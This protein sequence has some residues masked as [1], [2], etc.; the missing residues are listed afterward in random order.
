MQKTIDLLIVAGVI[1]LTV[2]FLKSLIDQVDNRKKLSVISY[3][4]G[5]ND[6]LQEMAMVEAETRALGT[7][8]TWGAKAKHVRVKLGSD[9]ST[10]KK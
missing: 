3:M 7:N 1:C 8:M 4:Q 6:S 10:D 9:K 2:W 5:V